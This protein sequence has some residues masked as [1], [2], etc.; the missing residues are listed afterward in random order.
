MQQLK[1]LDRA[2]NAFDRAKGRMADDF[3]TMISDG[4][5]L[6]KAAATVSGEGF[7]AARAKFEDQLKS[8][9]A[10]LAEASQP[11][12]DRTTETAAAANDYVRANPW[13]AVGVAIAAGTLIG[14]LAAK[15]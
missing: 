10:A 9:K 14:F 11:V 2:V 13:S 3:R 6:L 4:E 1:Q 8:A 15:R 5:D 7:T 12:F